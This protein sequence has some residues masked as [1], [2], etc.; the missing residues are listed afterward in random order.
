MSHKK[1]TSVNNISDS[2]QRKIFEN[3]QSHY[4]MPINDQKSTY[5]T[6]RLLEFKV[7]D[8]EFKILS[9]NEAEVVLVID[10]RSSFDWPS[11][12]IVRGDKKCKLT[13]NIYQV[14][15]YKVKAFNVKGLKFSFKTNYNLYAIRNKTMK[16]CIMAVDN[17]KNIKYVSKMISVDIRKKESLFNMCSYI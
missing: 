1:T 8:S 7:E 4:S 15:D 14:L 13:Q 3:K 2:S 10:N 5:Y 6:K 16:F 17:S 11:D 9:T 12:I